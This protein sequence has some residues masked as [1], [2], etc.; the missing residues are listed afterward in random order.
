V[1]G[2]RGDPVTGAARSLGQRRDPPARVVAD[3]ERVEAPE[4]RADEAPACIERLL[5]DAPGE[6]RSVAEETDDRDEP[7]G[8][9]PRSIYTPRAG[10]VKRNR[11]RRWPDSSDSQSRPMGSALPTGR[12]LAPRRAPAILDGPTVERRGDPV[13][14]A[15]QA[16]LAAALFGASTPASKLL[17]AE[18]GPLALAGLLYL[19]AALAM[20]LP[21][22][23]ERARGPRP[24]ADRA[25]RARLAGA[26][27]LG[28]VAGPVLLLEGLARAP[29]GSVALLLNLEM[30]AT[31]VLGA[32]CFREPLG[33]SG[34]LGAAGVV[35]AGAIVSG[36]GGWP[37]LAAAGLVATAC[38]A[39]A[40]DN[41]LTARIDGITPARSTF[42]KGAV[43]GTTNLTL[44]LAAA[45]LGA[46]GA[47]VLA[48]LGVGA[49]AYG[50]SVALYIAAAQ[51]LGATRAQGVFATAPFL[52]ASLAWLALGEPVT[53]WH[54]AGAAL[55]VPSV[56]L[57]LRAR[58]AHEHEHEPLEH[59]HAHRHDDGH[60]DHAH[61]GPAPGTVHSHWHRHEAVRHAHPHWPDLHHRHAHR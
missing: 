37:G 23:R 11:G 48:A 58:H 4:L 19:G 29:A 17:L 51:Q 56:A 33:R 2:E 6:R 38:T 57:L 43:A 10:A 25:S 18:L 7:R 31:A 8:T 41:H 9:S 59:V 20:A 40:V 27:L 42:W 14:G 5:E 32:A 52:G 49:L 61:P 3:P 12:R 55:L 26:V 35:A 30:A 34:W 54:V 28:G 16:L 60:H 44:G 50:A 21:L 22:A 53:V 36:G 1:V 13:R 45:P 46:G 47:T 15:L 39:W 24:R